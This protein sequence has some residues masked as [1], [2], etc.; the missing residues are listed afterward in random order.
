LI[1]PVSTGLP[2]GLTGLIR[3]N[4]LRARKGAI[5]LG[6]NYLHREKAMSRNPR[7]KRLS[8][9]Q[10]NIRDCLCHKKIRVNRMA[11]DFRKNNDFSSIAVARNKLRSTL[12][13]GALCG[14][15]SSRLWR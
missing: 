11:K 9:F 15:G 14:Y 6:W 5:T 7:R 4:I 10:K 12:G 1:S 13:E 8:A 3:I 2:A